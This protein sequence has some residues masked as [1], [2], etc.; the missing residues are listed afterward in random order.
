MRIRVTHTT[1]YDYSPAA[2]GAIQLLRLT[3]RGHEGQHVRSWRIDVDCDCRLRRGGGQERLS[4]NV[5]VDKA[6]RQVQS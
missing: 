5:H 1:R 6:Q 4:V 3:P 2:K